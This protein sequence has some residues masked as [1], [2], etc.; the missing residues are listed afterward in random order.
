MHCNFIY[1]RCVG[2][3]LNKEKTTK[4]TSI[5]H[6]MKSTYQVEWSCQNIV[7]IHSDGLLSRK[8][9]RQSVF[10]QPLA[11]AKDLQ[12]LLL[13]VMLTNEAGCDWSKVQHRPNVIRNSEEQHCWGYGA[14]VA[15][16][17]T[18]SKSPGHYNLEILRIISL[19]I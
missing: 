12:I 2:E 4:H 19:H 11:T 7:V 6:G 10:T 13:E 17:A 14:I 16:K 18:L 1:A 3:K 15:A 9:N 8:M 5:L